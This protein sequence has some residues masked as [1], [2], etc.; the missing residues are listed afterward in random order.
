MAIQEAEARR[1]GATT[2]FRPR[3][4]GHAN[5]YIGEL[6]RS[7]D[8][9]KNVIGLREAY[10]RPPIQAG[11]LNN[12][13]THHD[14][15]MISVKSKSAR[16]SK[17]GLNHLAWE[18]ETQVDLVEG[19]RRSIADGVRYD[20]TIDHEISHSVYNKDPDGNLNE[21]YA[22]TGMRW[23]KERYGDVMKPTLHWTPGDIPPSDKIHYEPNPEIIRVDHAVFHP[24]KITQAVLV[25]ADFAGTYDYYTR[26]VGLS[27]LMGS[28]DAPFAVLGGTL[29][30]RDL[31]L[32]R[33]KPNRPA[34]LHHISFEVWDESDLEASAARARKEGI[35]IV[36]EVDHPSRR[37]VVIA[38]PDGIRALFYVDR[39]A[40]LPNLAGMDEEKAIYLV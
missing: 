6:E 40:K 26:I 20:M 22:D 3:R 30:L 5:L 29:G 28:R 31:A 7:M 33:V 8:F 10:R 21:I 1:A 12:G 36:T 32:F 4:F 39:T 14:I 13:N 17:V 9:Y 34:E 2:Y 19:Y 35:K 38:D 15:G 24:K 11:F 37:G 27:P 25:V 23:Y 18:L 16:S